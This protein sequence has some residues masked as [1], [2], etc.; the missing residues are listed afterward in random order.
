MYQR[1]ILPDLRRA[2]AV[3]EMSVFLNSAAGVNK[4]FRYR[5][6][7][8]FVFIEGAFGSMWLLD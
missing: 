5:E 7:Y 8:S 1:N 6:A 3:F 2:T 4:L